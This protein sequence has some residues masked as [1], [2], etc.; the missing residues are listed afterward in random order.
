[1]MSSSVGREISFLD[2]LQ[3]IARRAMLEHELQ[4]DFPA[5]ALRQVEGM[6]QAPGSRRSAIRDL[7]S[8]P[9][10][11]IDNVESRDLDQVE[12]AAALDDGATK[13]LI[14]IADVDAL[15]ERGSAIDEHAQTNTTSVYTAA[16]VFSM[17]PEKLSTNLT[18]LN[19]GEDRLAMVIEM[20]ISATG[21]VTAADVY[22]A[23]VHN[24]AKMAYDSVAAWLDGNGPAPAA[25]AKVAALESQLRLQ[26]QASRNLR[27]LRREHGALSLQTV[28]ARP[29][30]KE[31][32]LTDLRADEKNRARDLI[33]DFM[34]AAN[35]VVARFLDQ[36]GRAS[37][38]RVLRSPE[39][40]VR[41]V[42]LAKDHGGQLPAEPDALALNH[43]L[44]ERREADPN[45]FADL[46]LS[47][48][49]LLGSGEYAME[50][51]Q[52]KA[53]GHFG[54]AVRDYTHSTAPNRRFPDLITQRLVKAALDNVPPPY[55]PEDLQALAAHCNGQARNAAKV[56][57]Q[58]RKAASAI[59]FSSRIGERFNGIVTGA[60]SK[61]TW[62]RIN[63][64]VVE[65]KVVRHF[66][67][68]DVGDRIEVELIHVNAERGFIDFARV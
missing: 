68:L 30:F 4:P 58:V 19:E 43:F 13:I 18:S 63:R 47:V 20:T 53:P 29:V 39:R 66:E 64:P 55:S 8:L 45:G 24:H 60:S 44:A 28:E 26:D 14:G 3:Q 5:A 46:S 21:E 27:T 9:W 33:E 56:E 42:A 40:W 52:Q 57:R 51:P 1:M 23:H 11:S 50:L 25:F 54:L 22:R 34:I 16:R 49:K 32:M 59:L 41:I 10:S 65:G 2:H 6:A 67:G 35:G 48:I 37:L 15:V 36:H 7:R 62:V 38:R 61:G 17:L 12:V 31:E